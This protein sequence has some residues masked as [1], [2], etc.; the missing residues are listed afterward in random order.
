MGKKV[1]EVKDLVTTFRIGKKEYEVLRGVSFDIEENET[2]CMVGESGCGKSVTTLSIMDLLPNNGRVVSG[3]I[4]LNGQELTTL[5][6]KERNALRGKQ[7]GMIF[8][9]P[10]TA[11]NPLLTIGR[12]MTEGLRLHLGM[13]REEAYETAVSYLEKVGIANPGDRMKQYPF[14]LSGGLR[15]RVMI[16][17]V[18]A[19]Q[20]SLLIADE[21]TT[22]LDVT[23]Q[24]Q[25]LVLLNRLKK[26][27]STGILF[28]THDLGVVAE[29]ADRVIILYSG[30]KVEEGS[31]EA[32]FSRPL[33]PYTVG[34]MKA[35]PN[36]DVDDF[37]IQPIPGTFPNI[38][39]EIGGCRFHP[40]CPYAT[41]RCRTEVPAEMEIAPGHFV[42]CHKVEE[43]HR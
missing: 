19:A 17:M 39:E 7:M 26:D 37:D 32:I 9:E 36:V 21:P 31:I 22:A 8:Q 18:M 27:V 6:P 13:S 5:S 24:K 33:H 2:L 28:I 25:V 3:S 29:I 43:E 1:L 14:Q 34:L 42:C 30:R 41:D 40:R 38:T 10:M 11:L 15:Q 35:V 4:K 20:P 16:A 12:Q 23:I